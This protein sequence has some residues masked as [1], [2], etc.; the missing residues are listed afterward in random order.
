MTDQELKV[1]LSTN[2]S[3]MVNELGK[4]SDGIVNIAQ[5]ASNTSL[6]I[7]MAEKNIVKALEEVKIR[8]Q[9]RR[10]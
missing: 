8:P 2:A 1:K 6:G 9:R 7:S 4:I 5:D 10:L 3:S